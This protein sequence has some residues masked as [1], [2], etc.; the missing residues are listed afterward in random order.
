MIIVNDKRLTYANKISMN[1]LGVYNNALIVIKSA[2]E[3][4]KY[5][6]GV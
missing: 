5:V 2:R 1:V 6:N 3:I 4:G